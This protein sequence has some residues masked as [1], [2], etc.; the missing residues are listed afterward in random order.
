MS[1][2]MT[3]TCKGKWLTKKWINEYKGKGKH[4]ETSITIICKETNKKLPYWET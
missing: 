3:N 4:A 2:S 1:W